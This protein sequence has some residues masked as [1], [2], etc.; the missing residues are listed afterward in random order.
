[1]GETAAGPLAQP[2]EAK[3]PRWVVGVLGGMDQKGRWRLGS[4][5]RIVALL[6]GV[7]LDL[8]QAEP[9]AAESLITVVAIFGG[10]EITAPPGVPVELTGFSLFGGKSDERPSGP[11]L[12]GCPV[13]RVRTFCVFGGV[14]VKARK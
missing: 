11:R 1:V 8:G 9:E 4:R 5:L 14:K 3:R 12:S 13:V 2:D 7:T 6:G 10:V